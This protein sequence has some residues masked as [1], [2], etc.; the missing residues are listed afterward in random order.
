MTNERFEELK[1]I[2]NQIEDLKEYIGTL[3]DIDY[4]YFDLNGR[5]N[6]DANADWIFSFN[7]MEKHDLHPLT[8]Y[9]PL[10]CDGLQELIISFLQEKLAKLE[11]EFEEA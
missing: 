9:H 3:S 7:N 8:D 10:A 5:Y 4:D 6:N 1:A 11:K 2:K